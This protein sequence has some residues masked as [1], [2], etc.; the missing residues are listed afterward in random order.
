[1]ATEAQIETVG[2]SEGV[3]PSSHSSSRMAAENAHHA[4]QKHGVRIG[5][6]L[7]FLWLLGGGLAV[8]LGLLVAIYAL[9]ALLV[10]IVRSPLIAER[11]VSVPVL[12]V[13]HLI[14]GAVAI[15]V[16]AFQLSSRIRARRSPYTAGSAGSTSSAC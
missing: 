12:L 14:G 9:T 11:I 6:V 13:L 5:G 3:A 4:L 1:M 16:G 8:L 10:P 2:A 15:A 7:R